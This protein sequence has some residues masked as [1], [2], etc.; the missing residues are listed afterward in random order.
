MSLPVGR[1]KVRNDKLIIRDKLYYE[2]S[3]VI[4]RF[5][6]KIDLSTWNDLAAGRGTDQEGIMQVGDYFAVRKIQDAIGS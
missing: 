6:W 5:P 4:S 2:E 3:K 1:G